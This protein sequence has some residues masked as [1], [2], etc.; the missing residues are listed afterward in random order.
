MPEISV[1]I[2]IYCEECGAGLCNGSRGTKTRMRGQPAFFVEPCKK[3]LED[4][5]K[6]GYD[7]AE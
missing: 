3:C 6:K 4:S 2:E 5:F 1:E 7:S